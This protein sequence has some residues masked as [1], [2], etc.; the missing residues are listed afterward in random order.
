MAITPFIGEAASFVAEE[1]DFVLDHGLNITLRV[2]SA[3]SESIPSIRN[4]FALIVQI[5]F[6]P[7]LYPD[8]E[9]CEELLE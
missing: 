3:G 2:N 4:V 9:L 6:D 7:E 1:K 5:N 8:T